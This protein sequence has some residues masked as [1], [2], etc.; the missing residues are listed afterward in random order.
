MELHL[1]MPNE[2]RPDIFKSIFLLIAK[3]GQVNNKKIRNRILSSP[4][5]GYITVEGKVIATA[6]IKIPHDSIIDNA[7]VKS[8]SDDKYEEFEFELGYAM[9]ESSFRRKGFAT[10]LCK[11]LSEIYQSHNLYATITA[12][13]YPAQL[14]L[15]KIGFNES[16]RTF[17]NRTDT[18]DL[19]LFI[20]RKKC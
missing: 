18:E 10:L 7:F 13:N 16:G 5:I 8:K 12:N 4:L 19:K 9:V 3:G 20:K 17:R 14:I 11:R 15:H 6:A 1:K 2:L